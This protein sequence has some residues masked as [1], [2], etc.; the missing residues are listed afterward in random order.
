MSNFNTTVTDAGEI[1]ADLLAKLEAA[2]DDPRSA[3][4]RKLPTID[5]AIRA[6]YHKKSARAIADAVGVSSNTI[7]KR[8]RELGL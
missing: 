3:Y 4:R 6:F 2:P 5:A 1:P 7:I 8:A